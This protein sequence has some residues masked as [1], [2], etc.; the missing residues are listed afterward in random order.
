MDNVTVNELLTQSW[1]TSLPPY[2]PRMFRMVQRY[3][4]FRWN[5]KTGNPVSSIRLIVPHDEIGEETVDLPLS[6]STFV[7]HDISDSTGPIFTKLGLIKRLAIE[8]QNYTDWLKGG[9][10]IQLKFQIMNKHISCPVW[11]TVMSFFMC[12]HFLIRNTFPITTNIISGT[13]KLNVF[14]HVL[15]WRLLLPYAAHR[16]VVNRR[17]DCG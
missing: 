17:R 8:K 7:T 11:A 4:M 6:V 10:S 12:M 9:Y 16:A 15:N 13:C 2:P 5:N 3:T 14:P 1:R